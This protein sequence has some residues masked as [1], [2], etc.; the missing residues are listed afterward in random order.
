MIKFQVVPLFSLLAL[1]IVAAGCSGN[2]PAAPPLP[3]QG[4][5]ALGRESAPVGK[6]RVTILPL[7]NAGSRP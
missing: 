3:G 7:H 4:A 2:P 6:R 5:Q 1:S